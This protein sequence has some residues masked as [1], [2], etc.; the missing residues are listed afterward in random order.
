MPD[1]VVDEDG[2]ADHVGE[3]PVAA[4]SDGPDRAADR[5]G[6]VAAGRLELAVPAGFEELQGLGRER[7]DRG[8]GC[9]V[10]RLAGGVAGRALEGGFLEF[11]VGQALG[12]AGAVLGER[13]N[14]PTEGAVL[15]LA[16]LAGGRDELQGPGE[17]V[18]LRSRGDLPAS[19]RGTNPVPLLRAAVSPASVLPGVA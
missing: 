4:V 1:E 14:R 8:V 5:G 6:G 9:L 3:G 17:R 15:G 11:E 16:D 18:D 12:D 10:L 13:E 2:V 19:V 7:R